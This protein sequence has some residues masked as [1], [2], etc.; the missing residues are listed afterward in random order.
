MKKVAWWMFFFL[1]FFYLLCQ[2]FNS[3]RV[4][5]TTYKQTP[6]KYQI[7][8]V[9]LQLHHPMMSSTSTLTWRY[10]A[11]KSTSD[12]HGLWQND[13][14]LMSMIH[15]TMSR[16]GCCLCVKSNCANSVWTAVLL[17]SKPMKYTLAHDDGSVY[18]I[19]NCNCIN[20]FSSNTKTY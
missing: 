18:S 3:I 9:L 4:Q 8:A 7:I 13:K 15:E 5:S 6:Q 2:S 19:E 10:L 12:G 1:L 11:A 20:F 16:R 17:E 14:T